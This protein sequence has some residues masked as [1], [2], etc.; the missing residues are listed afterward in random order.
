MEDPPSWLLLLSMDIK[1]CDPGK[2]TLGAFGTAGNGHAGKGIGAQLISGPLI[3][4]MLPVR[5]MWSG[6]AEGPRMGSDTVL[7]GIV[8]DVTRVESPFVDVPCL[9]GVALEPR[10]WV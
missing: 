2:L 7:H 10:T 5:E 4:P 9:D 1:V 3:F 6:S 8:A